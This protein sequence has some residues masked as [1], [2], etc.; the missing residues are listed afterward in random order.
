MHVNE[1]K[2]LGFGGALA[3]VSFPTQQMK[4][5]RLWMEPPKGKNKG[6]GGN[7]GENVFQMCPFFGG[8]GE[9]GKMGSTLR[10]SRGCYKI[11]RER[12]KYRYIE[13]ERARSLIKKLK[14]NGEGH[15]IK[16]DSNI[17]VTK[18][19]R[20]WTSH[21]DDDNEEEEEEEIKNKKEEERGVKGTNKTNTRH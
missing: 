14:K 4:V 7:R 12:E 16:S 2:E 3:V 18:G 1:K 8:G 11:Y 6:G 5:F 19:L 9:V 20:Q 10:I 17:V 21:D 13:R 15:V